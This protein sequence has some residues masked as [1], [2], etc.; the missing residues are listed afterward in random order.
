[1][2]HLLTMNWVKDYRFILLIL[3]FVS[4]NCFSQKKDISL[5]LYDKGVQYYNK[6][7]FKI[8]DSLF[9]ESIKLKPHKDTYFNRGVARY[10][11][12]DI[13]GFC[14]DMEKV[15]K[16]GDKEAGKIFDDN[17]IRIDTAY[18]DLNDSIVDQSSFKTFQVIKRRKYEDLITVKSYD[19]NNNELAEFYINAGDTIHGKVEISP[20]FPGGED[21]L[22]QY[23]RKSIHYPNLAKENGI[24]GTV[25]VTFMVNE[26]GFISDVKIMRGIG[27]GCDEEAKRIVKGMPKWENGT[28]LGKPVKVQYNLPVRYLLR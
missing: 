19:R 3:F 28:Y 12:N 5:E 9:T 7:K 22:F 10:K 24:S 18:Y 15:A 21:K 11:L 17:C 23:L 4:N 27:F 25:H 16:Y 1:M 2:Q 8:A 6:N 20:Q 14:F 13:K 26:D